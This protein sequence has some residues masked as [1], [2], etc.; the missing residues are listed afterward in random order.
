M[1]YPLVE[2]AVALGWMLAF[3][4]FGLSLSALRVSRRWKRKIIDKHAV[5][6]PGSA[7]SDWRP[8]VEALQQAVQEL[9]S[10]KADATVVFS[11]HFVRYAL[12]PLF[13]AFGCLTAAWLLIAAR[14][15]RQRD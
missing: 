3:M 10:E 9:R 4:E 14:M 8:C 6:C 13:V 12:V 15:G 11:N 7:S 1:Q 2:L 5:Q